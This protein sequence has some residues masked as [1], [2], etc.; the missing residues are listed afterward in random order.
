MA[1]LISLMAWI[2]A[3]SMSGLACGEG[4]DSVSNGDA[5]TARIAFASER[6]GNWEI[7]IINADGTGLANLTNN[8]ADEPVQTENDAGFDWSPNGSHIV[9]TSDRDDG[10][11]EIYVMNADGS[12]QTRVTNTPD[13]AESYPRWSPDGKRIA[14]VRATYGRD[15]QKSIHVM[16]ADGSNTTELSRSGVWEIEPAWSPDGRQI[17][18]DAGGIYVMNADGSNRHAL[19]DTEDDYYEPAWS[20]DGSRLS[21]NSY[22]EASSGDLYT[23]AFV[24]NSDGSGLIRIPDGAKEDVHYSPPT[25][26]PD[27]IWLALF[28]NLENSID[29]YAVRPD[30]S[31]FK[32]L[33]DGGVYL[34]PDWSPDGARL[35]FVGAE[36]PTDAGT[37][38]YVIDADGSGQ[39]VIARGVIAGRAAWAPDQ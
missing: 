11:P 25:W 27:G 19:I 16:D 9:F 6:D 18:F 26:S 4:E 28:A 14:F 17:A 37:D 24:I 5:P 23:Q 29:V 35:A 1:R 20:P 38:L 8:P 10:N 22:R 12:A 39:Q 32:R 15:S 31:A 34:G 36:A 2:A 33:T 13:A 3:M 30:G 21:F 7:F